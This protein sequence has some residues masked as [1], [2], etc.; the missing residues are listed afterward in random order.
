M[1]DRRIVFF[2]NLLTTIDMALAN[3]PGITTFTT[4]IPVLLNGGVPPLR[5]GGLTSLPGPLSTVAFPFPPAKTWHAPGTPSGQRQ[6]KRARSAA[7]TN[8]QSVCCVCLEPTG[9]VQAPSASLGCNHC[10]HSLCLWGVLTNPCLG[11]NSMMRCPMCREVVDRH[12]LAALGY[13]VSPRHLARVSRGCDAFRGLVSN[14]VTGPLDTPRTVLVSRAVLSAATLTAVD[15]FVYN[16]CL[17]A[18]DRMIHHKRQ[19]T[20]SLNAHLATRRT[21]D[22]C[23]FIASSLA[24]HVD[25]L[26]H[27]A[28][29]AAAPPE[30]EI[31]Q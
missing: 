20:A 16:A 10:L 29:H 18:L 3:G 23:D 7:S 27:T 17:L 25:V 5:G 8:R 22:R 11:A 30:S 24:C 12:G 13:D 31:P 4:S 19:F 1:S 21:P 6:R 2:P 26:I 15:G 28:Q 9:E 14:D